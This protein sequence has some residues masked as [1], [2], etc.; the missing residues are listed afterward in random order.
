MKFITTIKQNKIL[1]AILVLAT[2]LRIIHI[3]FQ[4]PWLDEIHTLNE[5]DPSNSLALIYEKLRISEPHPPLYFYII[6][7]LFK[8]FGYYIEVARLFSVAAGIASV[9]ALYLLGRELFNRNTGLIA[10]LLLSINHF[11]L[12]YSQ[13]A[14]PYT[15]FCLFSILA[16]YRLVLFIKNPSWKN[17]VYYSI[18]AALMLYGHFFA[19]LGLFAQYLVLLY[20]WIFSEPKDR[21]SFFVKSFISGLITLVLFLPSLGLF[22]LTTKIKSFWIAYPSADVYTTIYKGFFGDSELL[23][24]IFNILIVLY[25]FK[26][27]REEYNGKQTLI[28]NNKI[29]FSSLLFSVWIGVM[30]VIPLIR[31][32]LSLPMIVDRYF[33]NVLP[34]VLLMIAT[35]LSHFK[36]RIVLKTLTILILVFSLTSVVIIRKFYTKPYKTQF[37]EATAFI[38]NNNKDN[39][40]VVTSLGWYMSYFFK[41]DKES[42]IIDKP[43][44]EYIQKMMADPETIKSFWYIDGHNR[45]Y[46]L[47]KEAETF[48]KNN[49]VDSQSYDGFDVWTRKYESLKDVSKSINLKKFGLPKTNAGDKIN[50]NV[51]LIETNGITVKIQGWSYLEGSGTEGTMINLFLIK[52][53]EFVLLPSQRV[54][55]PD[56][57][58]YFNSTFNLENSGFSCEAQ[59]K[60][61]NTGRYKLAIFVSNKETNKEGLIITDKFIEI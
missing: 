51:E 16:L 14:R 31:S 17:A 61:I 21:K 15:F 37:R 8:I 39:L 48:I 19:L 18:V 3:G 55:R 5:A 50:Y 42:K 40:P 35:G 4:S 47:S 24:A 45:P 54:S 2:V 25:F 9:Y 44:E 58:P 46:A 27:S 32:H 30:L 10:A 6:H 20:F 11:H 33:I 41:S 43:L 60:D 13:D 59:L 38:I 34:V 12:Y 26:L 52:D 53:N 7:F 36:S 1:I 49:F 29:V 28:L 56:I 57:T 23:I 22:I